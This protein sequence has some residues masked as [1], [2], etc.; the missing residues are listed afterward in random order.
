MGHKMASRLEQ[1]NPKSPLEHSSSQQDITT[2]KRDI[3]FYKDIATYITAS[4]FT[5]RMHHNLERQWARV[6]HCAEMSAKA[7]LSLDKTTVCFTLTERKLFEN[8]MC[9][10]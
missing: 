10:L 9:F 5:L 7:V 1:R 6:D 2:S 4:G 8:S 3:T